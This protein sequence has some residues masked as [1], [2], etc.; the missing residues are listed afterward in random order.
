[1]LRLTDEGSL[2]G[3]DGCPGGPSDVFEVANH[4]IKHLVVLKARLNCLDDADVGPWMERVK[5]ILYYVEFSKNSL[6]NLISLRQLLAGRFHVGHHA[7]INYLN[8]AAPRMEEQQMSLLLRAAHQRNA[9][10]IGD[11][12]YVPIYQDGLQ[13]CAYKEFGTMHQFFMADFGQ[14]MLGDLTS[15][16]Q[17]RP[18]ELKQNCQALADGDNWLFPRFRPNEQLHSAENGLVFFGEEEIHFVGHGQAEQLR[19]LVDAAVKSQRE[20]GSQRPHPGYDAIKHHRGSVIPYSQ[21]QINALVGGT[22][23][24]YGEPNKCDGCGDGRREQCL[25]CSSTPTSIPPKEH[26]CYKTSSYTFMGADPDAD[27]YTI[28][29]RILDYQEFTAGIIIDY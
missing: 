3:P 16:L 2:I 26:D 21:D 5:T 14:G 4:V 17:S 8:Y 13:L 18:R 22:W 25:D 24:D 28:L 27:T 20:R 6:Y 11:K 19:N 7:P 1:M 29:Q 15:R 10:H 9:K 23:P 12:V